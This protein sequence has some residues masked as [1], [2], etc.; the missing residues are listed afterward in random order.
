MKKRI[1]KRKILINNRE[2][3]FGLRKSKRAGRLRLTVSCDDGVVVTL[4]YGT[5][6]NF[7]EKFILQKA[8]WIFAKIELFQK[9]RDRFCVKRNKEDYSEN[10]QKAFD[11]VLD[12]LSYFNNFYDFK[13]EKISIRDQKS[14]WG[15]CSKKGNLNFNYRIIFLPQNL[16]DYIIVH[17]L[18]HLKEFNHSQKFWGLVSKQIP[19]YQTIR[20]ELRKRGMA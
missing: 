11:F 9:Y 14:R 10:K 2:L 7:A 16:A 15:S 13:F 18:C 20:K 3:D 5:S 8:D 12:R 6:E 17:E 1:K 4:S 19:D